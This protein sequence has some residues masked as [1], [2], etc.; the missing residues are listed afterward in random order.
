MFLVIYEDHGHEPRNIA[1]AENMRAAKAC[2][3]KA[4]GEHVE[5][6]EYETDEDGRTVFI[7]GDA[8]YA[9]EALVHWS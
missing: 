3:D 6:S 4:C 5:D 7:I 1:T 8:Q 2:I 9:I